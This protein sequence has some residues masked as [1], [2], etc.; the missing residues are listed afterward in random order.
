[1]TWKGSAS[2]E[3]LRLRVGEEREMK[4]CTVAC[5]PVLRFVS[6]W[7]WRCPYPEAVVAL[8]TALSC[9]SGE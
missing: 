9:L 2:S 7:S 4:G 6:I 8:L 3:G 5:I 1:M